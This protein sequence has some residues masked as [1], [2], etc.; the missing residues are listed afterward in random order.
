MLVIL[1]Y[2]SG[3]AKHNAKG[4]LKLADDIVEALEGGML[5]DAWNF[6]VYWSHEL[7]IL[8]ICQ[9]VRCGRIKTNDIRIHAENGE[10]V[11]VDV[12]GSFITPWPTDLFDLSFYCQFTKY[13]KICYTPGK[14][15]FDPDTVEVGR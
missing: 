12:N 3:R 1:Q 15:T 6:P 5:E 2:D 9:A 14:S 13:D 7:T 8:R 10:V 11:A 4:A